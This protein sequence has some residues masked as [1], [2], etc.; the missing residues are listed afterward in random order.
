MSLLLLSGVTKRGVMC[1]GDV[2]FTTY[3]CGDKD[4]ETI[5]SRALCDSDSPV[6]IEIE[7]LLCVFHKLFKVQITGNTWNQQLHKG[8]IFSKVLW[9]LHSALWDRE[10]V[11]YHHIICLPVYTPHF[12]SVPFLFLFLCLLLRSFS[13]LAFTRHHTHSENNFNK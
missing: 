8:M 4:Q 1:L 13:N 2:K 5:S 11:L 12:L 6:G 9:P 3:V 10:S 7:L